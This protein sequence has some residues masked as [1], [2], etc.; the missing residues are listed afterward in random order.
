MDAPSARRVQPPL[1]TLA[2][3]SRGAAA[4]AGTLGSGAICSHPLRSQSPGPPP[5][6]PDLPPLR[7]CEPNYESLASLLEKKYRTPGGGGGQ[8]TFSIS[9]PKSPESKNC[10]CSSSAHLS[11]SR[12]APW[13]FQRCSGAGVGSG[14]VRLPIHPL[15][16]HIQIFSTIQ[17]TST[18]ILLNPPL[19]HRKKQNPSLL[20]TSL[21]PALSSGEDLPLARSCLQGHSHATLPQV[22]RKS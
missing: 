20:L 2:G 16:L 13:G 19:L 7:E 17:P 10:L 9:P 6:L 4:A 21:L 18:P 8:T 11:H 1:L 12:S 22:L 5:L 15:S 14:E 3:R